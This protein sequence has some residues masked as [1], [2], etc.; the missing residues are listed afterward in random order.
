MLDATEEQPGCVVG[1][2]Y[3]GNSCICGTLF[4]TQYELRV[5][6][7]D[8]DIDSENTVPD[9][10][11]F[12]IVSTFGLATDSTT[13][14][15]FLQQFRYATATYWRRFPKAKHA[16]R[17]PT[18]LFG[19][20]LWNYGLAGVSTVWRTAEEDKLPGENIMQKELP[21]S[22]D[23]GRGSSKVTY[24]LDSIGV[25]THDKKRKDSQGISVKEILAFYHSKCKHCHVWIRMIK[26]RSSF[27]GGRL[28]L[29]PSYP[30]QISEK[31]DN[32]R[33]GSSRN[34]DIH[35]ACITEKWGSWEAG[36][37][38]QRK[39]FIVLV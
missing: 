27:P 31:I 14:T 22:F 39:E 33:D 16:Y 5:V 4:G 21:L 9:D 38:A 13:S 7:C 6:S 30:R 35:L 29:H 10:E 1:E 11:L 32:T 2:D 34:V 24:G 20:I 37:C 25:C 15:L 26:S 23:I 12:K 19:R 18:S 3:S 36:W 28:P 17:G 8:N